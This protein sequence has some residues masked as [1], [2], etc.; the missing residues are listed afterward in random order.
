MNKNKKFH[1]NLWDA[2]KD[3]FFV[4]VNAVCLIMDI[5]NVKLNIIYLLDILVHLFINRIKFYFKN[6]LLPII[7]IVDGIVVKKNLKMVL[8]Y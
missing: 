1:L 8:H 2:K 7:L 4:I 5:N 6:A 3:V